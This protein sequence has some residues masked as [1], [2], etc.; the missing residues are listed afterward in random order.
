MDHSLFARR[1]PPTVGALRHR[2][3][4]EAPADMSDNAGGVTRN[5]AA[6]DQVWASVE[7]INANPALSDNR[8]GAR[9]LH[10]IQMRWR[11]DIDTSKRFRLGERVFWIRSV[12][13]AD[14]R[15]RR[16]AIMVEEETP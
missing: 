4:I 15:R 3:T 16:L 10:R 6:I 8:P 14:A 1:K 11:A 5:Y 13:D 9:V 2:L 12:A 7:T